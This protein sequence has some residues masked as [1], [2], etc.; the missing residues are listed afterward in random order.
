[1][2]LWNLVRSCGRRPAGDDP[3]DAWTLEWATSSPP[4]AYNFATLPPI[5]S[6]RPLWDLAHPPEGVESEGGGLV[7]AATGAG[8]AAALSGGWTP[9]APESEQRTAV[10]FWT[11]V[12]LLV[13]GAG[14]L[15]SPAVIV[16]GA[17]FLLVTLAVWMTAPWVEPHLVPAPGQRFS[18][19]G[20]G[21]LAFVGSETVFFASLIAADIHLRVHADLLSAG[22]GPSTSPS[23][24]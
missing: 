14:L 16:L 2:L 19:I 8:G 9:L 6:A 5:R 23:R 12:A 21:M 10:P 1:M 3:W 15:S 4:P 7:G 20:V 17:V 11:A 22:S 18:F 13:T 24:P